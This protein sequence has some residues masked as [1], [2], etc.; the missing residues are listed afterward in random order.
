MLGAVGKPYTVFILFA[1]H[2][3]NKLNLINLGEAMPMILLKWNDW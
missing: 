2:C 1:E 3:I